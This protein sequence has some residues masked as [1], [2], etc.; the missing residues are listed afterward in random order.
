MPKR[1]KLNDHFETAKEFTDFLDTLFLTDRQK[2]IA[3]Y[4]YL[5]GWASADIAAQLDLC[6][7][8]VTSELKEIRKVMGK[9]ERWNNID[10]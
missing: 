3:Y 2:K 9:T 8:T 1:S 6:R 4:K 5:R 10:N 7:R